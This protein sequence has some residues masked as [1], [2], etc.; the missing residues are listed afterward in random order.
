MSVAKYPDIAQNPLAE[1]LSSLKLR[2]VSAYIVSRE[3]RGVHSRAASRRRR[4]SKHRCCVPEHGVEQAWAWYERY[5]HEQVTGTR[6]CFVA[7]FD[8]QFEQGFGPSNPWGLVSLS[9]EHMGIGMDSVGSRHWSPLCAI[10][11]PGMVPI[12]RTT[13]SLEAGI[14]SAMA[15]L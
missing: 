11:W 1:D 8:G 15:L 10:A 14:L 9:G 2:R 4:P 7:A 5:F 3:K 13:K 12:Q 6:T